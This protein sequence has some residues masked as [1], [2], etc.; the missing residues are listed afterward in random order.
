MIVN[1]LVCT[2]TACVEA[3]LVM[4]RTMFLILPSYAESAVLAVSTPV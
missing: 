1:G 3:R 4:V 2:V